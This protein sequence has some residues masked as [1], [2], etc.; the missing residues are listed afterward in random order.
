MAA[1]WEELTS[2]QISTLNGDAYLIVWPI[3]SVEQHGP[4]L[5][6]GTDLIILDCL[7]ER[8]RKKLGRQ[9]PILW[10]PT[11]SLGKS[12]EH[13][14]FAG[15][16]SLRARTLLG[17]I[18]DL[19]ASLSTHGFRHLV[20]LNGHGGNTH[21][22]EALGPD[23]LRDY[24]VRMYT[25]NLWGESFLNGVIRDCFPQLKRP[26]I[27]AGA[28]ETSM[29]LYLRPDL[30]GPLPTSLPSK[31]LEGNAFYALLSNAMGIS[32]K[33]EDFGPLGVIGNPLEASTEVGERVVIYAVNRICAI[34]EELCR[35]VLSR[36]EVER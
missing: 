16:V 24:N 19:A 31:N 10:G 32:W 26:D 9:L 5:P 29:M 14:S 34:L 28:V 33:A 3:A 27:H 7:V 30:V 6:V 17:I 8:V 23:I 4:Y 20:L 36:K 13:L 11:L 25:I 18:E 35:I 15:T 21:L 12:S 22:L 1:R 2:T